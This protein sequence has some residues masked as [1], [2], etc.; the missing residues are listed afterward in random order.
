MCDRHW[1]RCQVATCLSALEVLR[2]VNLW[3]CSLVG[4]ISSVLRL[5]H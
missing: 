1:G 3:E 2:V 5:S 4:V